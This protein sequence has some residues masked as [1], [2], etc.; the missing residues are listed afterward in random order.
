[1]GEM[2][3]YALD[4]MM[5]ADEAHLRGE[6]DPETGDVCSSPFQHQYKSKPR[7]PGKCPICG[8]ETK[9]TTGRYGNFYSCKA[10]PK[11]RGTRKH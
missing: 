3:D 7:G 6:I 8:E 4:Q 10:F 11:C 9:L 1:M 2:A 5:D